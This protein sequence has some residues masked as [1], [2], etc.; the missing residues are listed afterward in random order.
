MRALTGLA[1]HLAGSAHTRCTMLR[2]DLVDGTTLAITDHD[3]DLTYDLGDGAVTYSAG[4]GIMPSDLALAVGFEGSDIEVEGP[5][6]E[7]VTRAA[8]LGGRYDD[9]AARLFQVNWAD[10]TAG[11]IKLLRGRV[12]LA[13]VEGGRFRLTIQGEASKFAQTV[14]RVIS[15][16]CDADFGDARCAFAVVPVAATVASVTDERTIIVTFT[17]SYADDYFNR[18][19]ATFTSGA[20]NGCRP[21]EINDWSAAGGVALWTGL[22]EAPAIGDTLELRQGCGKTRAD[23]MAFAN[24][25]NFRGFADVPGSDQVLRYPNPGG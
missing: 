4:T 11:A 8:V 2:L 13:Q 5:I 7:V 18:G 24:I 3:R 9:A 14:G 12:V 25:V 21:V 16:Y 1:G 23:C 6:A 20:L 22:P 15:A 19:T 17:G 10:L